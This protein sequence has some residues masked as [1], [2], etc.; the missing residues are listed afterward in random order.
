[1][2]V[3]IEGTDR[4]VGEYLI[5][6]YL[7]TPCALAILVMNGSPQIEDSLK[8]CKRSKQK[9]VATARKNLKLDVLLR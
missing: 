3:N 7:L 6:K 5:C 4:I 8:L 1:M 2:N 9:A